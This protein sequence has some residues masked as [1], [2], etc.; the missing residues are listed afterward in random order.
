MV[1]MGIISVRFIRL[2]RLSLML[3]NRALRLIRLLVKPSMPGKAKQ[4]KA[5]QRYSSLVMVMSADHAM[6][7]G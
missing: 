1:V 3:A 7:F 2:I 5:L 4:E 6:A